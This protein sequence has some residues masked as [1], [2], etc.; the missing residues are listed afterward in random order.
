MRARI[1]GIN[2]L[3]SSFSIY[4]ALLVVSFFD[5]NFLSTQGL[6]RK[7]WDKAIDKKISAVKNGYLPLFNPHQILFDTKTTL[8]YP[9]GSLPLTPT[10]YCDEGY[11]LVTYTTDR[12]GLR[13]NDLKWEKVY[14]DSN[15][16]M[17]GDSFVQGACVPDNSTITNFMQKSSNKNVLN[18]GTAN[19]GP[20]EYQVILKSLVKPIIDTSNE[21]NIVIIAFY[22]NDN[23]TFNLN[24]ENLIK[25]QKSVI[26][27][28][29]ET[30]IS[31]NKYYSETLFRVIKDKYPLSKKQMQLMIKKNKK[32]FFYEV[33]TLYPIR[34]RIGL[35]NIS[36]AKSPYDVNTKNNSKSPSH[37]AIKF[38][39]ETCQ[40]LCLPY[41]V[42][43]PNSNY[44]RPN[45]KANKYKLELQN[46]SKNIGIKFIDG[47]NI[48]NK[49]NRNDYAPLGGHLSLEGYEKIADLIKR[50]IID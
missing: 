40:N 22:D 29:S 32:P 41:V 28:D 18:L 8:I 45:S 23:K 38:L 3:L 39:A 36:I 7:A 27:L 5:Y 47:E 49:N 37:N 13:N 24:K 25:K 35:S 1:I 46:I 50:N 44:W 43:I 11:G 9:I 19:N 14:S 26:K 4:L 21:R 31:P 34:K 12:F 6:E 10:Y 2:F 33:I 17:I 30:K 48:I 42:Y 20:Y 16:F 15:I